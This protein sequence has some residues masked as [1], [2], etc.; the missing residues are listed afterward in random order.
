MYLTLDIET[1]GNDL[2]TSLLTAYFGVVTLTPTLELVDELYLQL[3]HDEYVVTAQGLAVNKIDLISHHK[4]AEY[5][6]TAGQKLRTF[7]QKHSQNGADKLIPVGH[8]LASDLTHIYKGLLSR[9]NWEQFVSYRRLDTGTIAQFLRLLGKIPATVSG[10]LESLLDYYD[11]EIDVPLHHA[12]TDA[13]ATAAVL[14]HQ[15]ATID[16]DKAS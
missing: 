14:Y 6:A 10:S 16:L 9:E 15:Q 13:L 4:E 7:L 2:S 1:G 3:K 8:G 5:K 11:I 12:R